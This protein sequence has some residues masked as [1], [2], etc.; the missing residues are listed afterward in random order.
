MDELLDAMRVSA[1]LELPGC[2]APG[3]S[4]APQSGQNRS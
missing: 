3:S 2:V 4:E 1:A